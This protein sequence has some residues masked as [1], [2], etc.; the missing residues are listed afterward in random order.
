MPSY[1]RGRLLTHNKPGTTL[2]DVLWDLGAP[3]PRKTKG[4]E[5]RL[6]FILV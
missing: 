1:N 2:R 3:G 5:V 6:I 4:P